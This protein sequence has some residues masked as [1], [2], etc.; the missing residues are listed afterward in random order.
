M[1]TKAIIADPMRLFELGL[2]NL[3]D[4][5]ILVHI[6]RCGIIGAKRTSI[7]AAHRVSYDTARSGVDRLCELGLVT[8]ISKDY[9]VGTPFNFVCTVKGWN[10]LTTP[11]DFSMFPHAQMSLSKDNADVLAPAGDKTQPKKKDV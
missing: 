3:M 7:A 2:R 11:A 8:S 9:S 6:G 5:A 4:M 10:L 1:K